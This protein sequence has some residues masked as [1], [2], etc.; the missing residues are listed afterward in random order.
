MRLFA[1]NVQISRFEFRKGSLKSLICK[2]ARY[3]SIR[4]SRILLLSTIQIG[5]TG[6]CGPFFLPINFDGG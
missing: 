5:N 6:L 3:I 1:T 4:G 2:A